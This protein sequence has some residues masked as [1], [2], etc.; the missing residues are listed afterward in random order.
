MHVDDEDHTQVHDLAERLCVLLPGIWQYER[1]RNYAC[2]RRRHRSTIVADDGAELTIYVSTDEKRICIEPFASNDKCFDMRNNWHYGPVVNGLSVP[3]DAKEKQIVSAMVDDGFLEL[4]RASHAEAAADCAMA[5][6]G[7]KRQDELVA[8][9][10]LDR[11]YR[12]RFDGT[13]H[14]ARVSATSAG[15]VKIEIFHADPD[16]VRKLMALLGHTL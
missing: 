15:A 4:A 13:D 3:R 11:K 10:G 16:K 14:V 1:R 7:Y 6:A 12:T 8:E 9:L 2:G 5:N